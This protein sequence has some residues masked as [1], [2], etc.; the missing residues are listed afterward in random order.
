MDDVCQDVQME[1]KLQSLDGEILSSNSTTSDDDARLDI[2]ALPW[3]DSRFNRTFFDVKFFNPHAKSCPETIKDAYR[4]HSEISS[5]NES[6]KPN[7]AVST[8]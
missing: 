5:K 2:I 7:T 3:W 8:H 6:G 1:P 4:Y